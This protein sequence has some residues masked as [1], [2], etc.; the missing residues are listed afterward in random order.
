[1]NIRRIISTAA[2]TTVLCASSALAILASPQFA[3][4]GSGGAPVSTPASVVRQAAVYIQT[5]ESDVNRACAYE[6]AGGHATEIAQARDDYN[7][8]LNKMNAL[9]WSWSSSISEVRFDTQTA[10]NCQAG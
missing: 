1:M 2:I 10:N 3:S 8:N 5:M 7:S 4:A 9:M 6:R